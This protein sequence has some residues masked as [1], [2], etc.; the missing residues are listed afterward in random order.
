MTSVFESLISETWAGIVGF[1]GAVAILAGFFSNIGK[2]RKWFSTRLAAR[3]AR[4]DAPVKALALISEFK[5]QQEAVNADQQRQLDEIK[6]G[7]KGLDEQVAT[8]Q[9]EK[10]SWAYTYYG[11]KKKPVPQ[12]TKSSLCDMFDQ[13]TREGKHNHIPQDFKEKI[14]SAPDD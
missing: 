11:V 13:Y 8:V 6:A 1:A 7:V 14:M 4:K 12:V 2:L 5:S 10:M 9:R 3:K